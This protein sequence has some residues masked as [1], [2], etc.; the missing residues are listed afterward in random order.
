MN[1]SEG[2]PI[3]TTIRFDTVNTCSFDGKA[4]EVTN[5]KRYLMKLLDL[6]L[7]PSATRLSSDRRS[8]LNHHLLSP[9]K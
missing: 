8:C 6:R 2:G 3:P 1:I 9:V 5:L 7:R 4:F